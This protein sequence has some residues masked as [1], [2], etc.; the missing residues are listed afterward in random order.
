MK[1]N[2]IIGTATGYKYA[3]MQY[4]F[5]SLKAIDFKGDVVILVS[6]DIDAE[7]KQLLLNQDV[8]LIYIKKSVLSFSKKYAASRLW[9]VHYLF[10]KALYALLSPGKDNLNTLSKYVKTFHLVSGSRYCYYYEYLL[11]N[12]DK[13][14][15]VLITDVRDVLFQAD[16]FAGIRNNSF[17]NFYSEAHSIANSFYTSYWLRHA[18]G[19]KALAQIADKV[20]ICSGTTIGS[21]N[22]II[23][24]L[25]AM[26]KMQA[27]ITAGLTGLGG[28]DQGVHNYLVHNNYF[29]GSNLL[30][31]NEGEVATLGE[32][33]SIAVNSDHELTDK[34]GHVIPVV[35]QF[36][37]FPDLKLKALL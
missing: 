22:Q 26:I 7:T 32:S 25:E 9:K 15:L 16:P 3:A 37:R 20:S 28:F 17:L 13:Y 1:K 35:H 34:K 36:D 30:E 23:N 5:T 18:F 14:D 21:V 2:L 10:H 12:Q 8:I 4:F 33:N 19:K 31:N 24:Y 6:D 11:A 29:P 27:K